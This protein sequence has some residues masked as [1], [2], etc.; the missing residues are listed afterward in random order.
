MGYLLFP[1]NQ[2]QRLQNLDCGTF[3]LLGFSRQWN[4]GSSDNRLM[5]HCPLGNGIVGAENE[6]LLKFLVHLL[7]LIPHGQKNVPRKTFGWRGMQFF[8]IWH[9]VLWEGREFKVEGQK[10][11]SCYKIEEQGLHDAWREGRG[12]AMKSQQFSQRT[13]SALKEDCKTFTTQTFTTPD[14]H[15]PR[16]SPTPV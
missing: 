13:L 7:P 3:V 11:N 2:S 8:E 5:G 9:L 14:V 16:R 12:R 10:L 6:F 15:H 4:R 1:T